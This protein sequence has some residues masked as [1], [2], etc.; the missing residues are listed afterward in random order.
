[1]P[2]RLTSR[3]SGLACKQLLAALG[4]LGLGLE[5]KLVLVLVLVLV[6][7]LCFQLQ[8]GIAIGFAVWAIE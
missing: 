6:L 3:G 2:G 5:M 8:L 7:A 4:W 1:M